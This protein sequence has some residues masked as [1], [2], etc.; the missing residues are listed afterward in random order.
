[1]GGEFELNQKTK[2]PT[3]FS[4]REKDGSPA[5]QFKFLGAKSPTFGCAKNGAPGVGKIG[6]LRS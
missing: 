2:S 4:R 3:L 1:M 5:Q 6:L